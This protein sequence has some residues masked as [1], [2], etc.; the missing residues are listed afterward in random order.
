MIRHLCKGDRVLVQKQ[1]EIE[2]GEIAVVGIEGEDDTLMRVKKSNNSD[3]VL[4]P[5]N[6]KC[7]PMLVQEGNAR[8]YGKVV[9]V[10]FTPM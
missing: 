6:T 2:S 9:Q 1:T 7:G 3:V 8:I 5:D 10:M 4:Y